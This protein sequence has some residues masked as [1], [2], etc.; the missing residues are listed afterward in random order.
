MSDKRA[1]V[2][3]TREEAALE[4]ARSVG[5]KA[6]TRFRLSGA[7]RDILILAS[8]ESL[9]SAL[10]IVS[11]SG[12]TSSIVGTLLR[13]PI[14]HDYARHMLQEKDADPTKVIFYSD[15]D[16]ATRVIHA[17][18]IGAADELIAEA[19]LKDGAL[20]V[21]SC[22]F[23]CLRISTEQIPQLAAQSEADRNEFYVETN[24]SYLHWPKADLHLDLDT[25]RTISNP[26]L[27]KQRSQESLRHNRRLGRAIKALRE[28]AGLQKAQFEGID[29]RQLLRLEKGESTPR[30]RTLE[31]LARTHGISLDD[32]LSALAERASRASQAA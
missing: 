3:L 32:Y 10:Q 20:Y 23:A 6:V 18:K 16:V 21:R 14:Q 31:I 28:E 2:V 17:W 1:F 24:G 25:V 13:E 26:D 30:M 4:L 12:L 27:A 11:G 5:A 8:E 19:S 15:S 22:G 29:P 9:E 7:D